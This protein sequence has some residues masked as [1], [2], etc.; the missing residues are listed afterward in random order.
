[1]ANRIGEFFSSMPDRDEAIDGIANHLRNYWEPR[2]RLQLLA[3]ADEELC[4]SGLSSI[5]TLTLERKRES[6]APVPR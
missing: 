6:I 2:M 5:V 1:M 3:H 4:D